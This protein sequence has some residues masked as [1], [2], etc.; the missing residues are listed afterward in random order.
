MFTAKQE[1]RARRKPTANREQQKGRGGAK[2]E[3]R[4]KRREGK[5]KE[6]GKGTR[7]KEERN[8]QTIQQCMHT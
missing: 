8:L 1:E 3:V 6:G 4:E 7:K 5:G 2:I